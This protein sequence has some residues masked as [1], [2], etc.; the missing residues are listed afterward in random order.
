MEKLKVY[1][2]QCWRPEKELRDATTKQIGRPRQAPMEEDTG[3]Q[4]DDGNNAM[5]TKPLVD[6]KDLY[7]LFIC[8]AQDAWR[9]D[10]NSLIWKLRASQVSLVDSID[11]AD[12]VNVD[13]KDRIFGKQVF[14]FF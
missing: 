9:K 7:G 12:S 5:K 1:I 6:V 2:K 8:E 4:N 13:N 11:T 3:E 10:A 14:R